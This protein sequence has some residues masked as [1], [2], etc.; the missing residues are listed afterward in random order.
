MTVIATRKPNAGES[1]RRHIRREKENNEQVLTAL[2]DSYLKCLIEK[3][4]THTETIA[5][6][7]FGKTRWKYHC[8]KWNASPN[9]LAELRETD[10][11][12]IITHIKAKRDAANKEYQWW[13]YKSWNKRLSLRSF[14][15]RVWL[16]LYFKWKSAGI[17]MY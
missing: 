15:D 8:T 11:E 13:H 12:D 9:R 17:R 6:F 2:I 3:G 14:I 16:G 1:F 7:N 5:T 4:E 10:Y